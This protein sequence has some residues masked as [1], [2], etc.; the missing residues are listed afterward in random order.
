MVDLIKD[1]D[2]P[3]AGKHRELEKAEGKKG[4]EAIQRT[5][6]TIRNFTNPFTISDK[7]RL[8]SLASGAPVLME[9]EMDVLQAE[10]VGKRSSNGYRA[11]SQVASLTQ[12]KRRSSRPACNKKVTL[13]SSQGKVIQYQEQS[14]LAFLHLPWDTSRVRLFEFFGVS[15]VCP[16]LNKAA[17]LHYI[18]EDTTPKD[19]P[20][21][22]DALFIQDGMAL[23][24]VLTNL[25]PTCAEICLQVLDQMVA[26]KALFVLD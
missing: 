12:S 18:L 8:Y 19:L 1:P 6:E 20:Y 4:E 14:N 9:V 17:L 24:H 21:P 3:R 15:L 10:T 11:E 23:L 25:P 16:Y 26:K 2:C 7:D 5:I 22:K 13:T